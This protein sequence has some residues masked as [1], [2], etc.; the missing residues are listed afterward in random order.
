M[1]EISTKNSMMA[2]KATTRAIRRKVWK[3]PGV[4][5]CIA[6]HVSCSLA[7]RAS[8]RNAPTNLSRQALAY[9][10]L[11]LECLDLIRNVTFK[12]LR[13]RPVILQG[14]QM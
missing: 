10:I 14:G 11:V 7:V 5:P 9:R 3:L 13:L 12:E 4:Y 8:E 1:S 6:L 2:Q